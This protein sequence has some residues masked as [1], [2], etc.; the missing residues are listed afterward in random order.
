MENLGQGRYR[1]DCGY[2]ADLSTCNDLVM[3]S[4]PEKVERAI[5]AARMVLH[6]LTATAFGAC[7]EILRP[8]SYR[9]CCAPAHPW[10]PGVLPWQTQLIN[11]VF[12]NTVCGCGP[13]SV[14]G[15]DIGETEVM[16]VLVDGEPFLDWAVVR[17]RLVSLQG[18]WP[19][20]QD[21]SLAPDAVGAFAVKV[22]RT[23]AESPLSERALGELAC[24]TLKELCGL[25]CKLPAGV[26]TVVRQGVTMEV[27]GFPERRTGLTYPDMLIEQLNPQGL[28]SLAALWSPHRRDCK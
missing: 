25:K 24:E 22:R 2:V 21:L 28:T 14:D 18:Q 9:T 8:C 27:G 16:E 4:G 13:C 3:D 26:R 1:D 15:I 20:T 7:P 12:L 17:G 5:T 11:G 10:G 23:V 19:T 6:S